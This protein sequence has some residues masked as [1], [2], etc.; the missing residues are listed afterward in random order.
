MLK[1]TVD[2]VREVNKK[3][4]KISTGLKSLER[5]LDEIT[6]EW[7]KEYDDNF[8]A[9][10]RTLNQPWK[11]RVRSYS[12]PLLQKSGKLRA[13]FKRKVKK[14]YA[15]IAN[16]V[17]WAKYHQFGT[18]FLPVRRLIDSTSKMVDF[19]TKKINDYVKKIIR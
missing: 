13:G 3:L 1:V 16:N 4:A 2:G 14:D 17:K 15:E 6:K 7:M 8:Q 11:P 18:A 10:G 19:A 12:W 5:P 9:Q